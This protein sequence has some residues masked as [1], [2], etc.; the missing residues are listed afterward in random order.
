MP[1][2]GK[3]VLMWIIQRPPM[4]TSVKIFWVKLG[5]GW[6]C[7]HGPLIKDIIPLLRIACRSM[8]V[9]GS[10]VS[11]MVL[12]AARLN[13][14]SILLIAMIS[15]MRIVLALSTK[16]IVV[17]IIEWPW[18]SD[19]RATLR[20]VVQCWTLRGCCPASKRLWNSWDGFAMRGSPR[21]AVPCSWMSFKVLLIF[22]HL[23]ALSLAGLFEG[24]LGCW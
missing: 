10:N 6:W 21:Q 19:E 20:L 23:L 9:M 5:D 22:C 13:I 24:W 1:S 14:A 18:L 7:P 17:A 3:L 4:G 11:T 12:E 8:V 16:I 15:R 2:S